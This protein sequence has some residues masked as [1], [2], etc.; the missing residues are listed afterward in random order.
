MSDATGQPG[1]FDGPLGLGVV[2]LAVIAGAMLVERLTRPAP[3]GE[4]TSPLPLPELAVQGWLNTGDA[5]VPSNESL[6]GRYVVADFWATDCMPCLRSLPRLA[7]FY[8][9]WCDRGV[10]VLGLTSEPASRIGTI[11]AAIARVDGMDWPVAYGAGVVHSKMNVSMIPTYV[12]FDKEGR[13]VWRGH[14]LDDL[15][16]ELLARF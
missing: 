1:R 5:S 2:L 9:R 8:G 12:L 11:E 16:D 13:S 3:G 10:E 4:A 14:S 15:E 7:R 6:L